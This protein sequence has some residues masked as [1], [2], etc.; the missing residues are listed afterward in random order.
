MSLYKQNSCNQ[1]APNALA[2]MAIRTTLFDLISGIHAEEG[3]HVSDGITAAVID[4]FK[5]YHISCLGDFAG[6]RMI[7]GEQETSC[8]AVA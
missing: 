8:S 2:P 4:A 3:S 1:P 7:L 6:S 5:T